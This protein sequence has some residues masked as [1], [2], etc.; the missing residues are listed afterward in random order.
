MNAKSVFLFIVI[1]VLSLSGCM[2]A[3]P[4]AA[5]PPVPSS[6]PV[7]AVCPAC[8]RAAT[9][10]FEGFQR[11]MPQSGREPL[12]L[13]T[14]SGCRSTRSRSDILKATWTNRLENTSKG[15][16]ALT[17]GLIVGDVVLTAPEM[18]ARQSVD[19]TGSYCGIVWGTFPPQK[20]EIWEGNLEG[21]GEIPLEVWAE[22]GQELVFYNPKTNEF[23]EAPFTLQVGGYSLKLVMGDDL[24]GRQTIFIVAMCGA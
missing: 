21:L 19:I 15:L 6:L 20:G 16:T 24:M 5:V 7:R 12:E 8:G 14:C 18:A 17:I 3:A 9:W 22:E 23:M 11:F 1:V 4:E 10:T 2:G 13:W